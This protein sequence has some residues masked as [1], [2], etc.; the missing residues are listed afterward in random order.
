MV[1]VEGLAVPEHAVDDVQGLVMTAPTMAI[2]GLPPAAIASP[3]FSATTACD[4]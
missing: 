2:D 4:P 3:L 1:G